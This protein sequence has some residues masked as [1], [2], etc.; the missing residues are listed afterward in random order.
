MEGALVLSRALR[1]TEPFDVAVVELARG[2]DAVLATHAPAPTDRQ[3]P[4][5]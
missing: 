4:T 2:V 1:T 5:G 3:G